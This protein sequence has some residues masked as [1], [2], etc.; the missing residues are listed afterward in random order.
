MELL[1]AAASGDI[2]TVQR[3]LSSEKSVNLSY[4]NEVSMRSAFTEVII[5]ILTK[6]VTVPQEG[7]SA[8]H[9]AAMNGHYAVA[10]ML[11]KINFNKELK[12]RDVSLRIFSDNSSCVSPFSL[13]CFY[14]D[15]L[16][17]QLFTNQLCMD[18][19]T[20]LNYC[21]KKVLTKKREARYGCYTVLYH[22]SRRSTTAEVLFFDLI[23]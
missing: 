4:Q 9:L 8:L 18:T 2:A 17:R 20:F 19:R 10:E 1:Q 22:T 11:L 14:C 15:R 7:I 5:G 13:D 21:C 23:K 6:P 16:G 12:D 3:I